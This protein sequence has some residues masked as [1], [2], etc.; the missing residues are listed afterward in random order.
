MPRIRPTDLEMR[1]VDAGD[2]F[3]KLV[4]DGSGN[5]EPLPGCSAAPPG[6]E[7]VTETVTFSV[8]APQLAS[9]FVDFGL[10]VDVSGSYG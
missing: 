6:G 8:T 3:E 9:T 4:D 10:L 2:G 5:L 1:P 7:N